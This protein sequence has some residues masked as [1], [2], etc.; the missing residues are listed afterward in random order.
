M[1]CNVQVEECRMNKVYT[2]V[3][4]HVLIVYTDYFFFK[5]W[6]NKQFI[7]YFIIQ[8]KK[9]LHIGTTGN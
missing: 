6:S 5:I 2:D 4:G 1:V 8:I 9:K 3:T 7:Y